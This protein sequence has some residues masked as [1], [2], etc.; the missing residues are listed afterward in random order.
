MA[1]C[2]AG[3]GDGLGIPRRPPPWLSVSRVPRRA[4]DRSDGVH[5]GGGRLFR[6]PQPLRGRQSE[7]L[8]LSVS[9]AVR[10]AVG[11]ITPVADARSG[12]GLVLSETTVGTLF[13]PPLAAVPTNRVA[14]EDPLIEAGDAVW[15]VHPRTGGQ[16][17]PAAA[18]VMRAW[19]AEGRI[20]AD[21]L[22]W[23]EGW[24]NWQTA[25]NVFPEL[26]L[27]STASDRKAET[28]K[29]KITT[30]RSGGPPNYRP[31]PTNTVQIVFV[32][33]LTVAAAA[34]SLVLYAIFKS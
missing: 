32:V 30:V 9:A 31:R 28:S 22:V 19:I 23:H 26:S 27:P 21:S 4:S 13:F 29:L 15:Y 12:D 10:A 20:S 2:L 33:V 11:P 3:G 16:F 7:G 5:R 25:G 14:V 1:D 34:L 18:D 17:G 6:R 8:D 24:Q